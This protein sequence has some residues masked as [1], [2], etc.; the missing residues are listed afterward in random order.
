MKKRLLL[1]L[2]YL[3]FHQIQ[4]VYTQGLDGQRAQVIGRAIQAI[5]NCDESKGVLLIGKLDSADPASKFLQAL[6]LRWKDYPLDHRAEEFEEMKRLLTETSEEVMSLQVYEEFENEFIRTVSK[7]LLALYGLETSQITL[8][9]ARQTHDLIQT[10]KKLIDDYNEFLLTTGIYN[11]LRDKIPERYFLGFLIDYSVSIFFRR[12]NTEKGL[13]QLRLASVKTFYSKYEA[14][15]YLAHIN[16]RYEQ[17]FETCI[18]I[19]TKLSTEFPN[20][21][22]FKVLLAESYYWKGDIKLIVPIIQKIGHT[23]VPFYQMATYFF[24]GVVTEVLNGDFKKAELYYQRGMQIGNTIENEESDVYK[25]LIMR[26]LSR[27]NSRGRQ[28]SRAYIKLAKKKAP[29]KSLKKDP[30][31]LEKR[32]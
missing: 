19:L 2:L 29:Y 13:K 16:L 28:V 8:K 32:P 9:E 27:V 5:Y 4:S 21:D 10:G 15:L 1:V 23:T 6:L 26:G 18:D 14:K 24:Q 31:W 17:E 30:R 3:A 20:N 12:G 25:T 22:F 11:Y 7:A